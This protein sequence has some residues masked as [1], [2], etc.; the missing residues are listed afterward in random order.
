MVPHILE[1]SIFFTSNNN[2]F[3]ASIFCI[4]VVVNTLKASGPRVSRE[5]SRR[6]SCSKLPDRS[7]SAPSSILVSLLEDRSRLLSRVNPFNIP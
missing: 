2:V 7:S 4:V 3:L 5:L 6:L 1:Y